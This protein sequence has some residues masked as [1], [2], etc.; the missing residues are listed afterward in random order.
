MFA[1]YRGRN[2]QNREKRVSISHHPRKGR[3]ESKNPHFYT[4][5]HKENGDF[6]SRSALFWGG[7]K[8]GFF[9]SET[10]FSRFWGFRPLLG[11]NKFLTKEAKTKQRNGLSWEPACPLQES[12]I[13]KESLEVSPNTV[14]PSP[15]LLFFGLFENTKENLKNSKDFAHRVNPQKPCKTSRKHSKTQEFPRKKN[16]KET[17]TPRKR[18]TGRGPKRVRNKSQKSLRSLKRDCSETPETLLRLISDTFWTPGPD[19]PGI[20]FRRLF[21]DFR[22]EA[23]RR[24]L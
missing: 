23:P 21:G 22:P 13:P 20:L 15:V 7:G 3:S 10:L 19:A 17:K 24:L 12:E 5:L 2:P 1:P 8:W 4:E 16:T 6:L 14:R 18:R 11:A 9:E